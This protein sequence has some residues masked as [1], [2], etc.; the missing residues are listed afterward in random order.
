MAKYTVRYEVDD[1]TRIVTSPSR[2]REGWLQWDVQ[3]RPPM[4]ENGTR[5][6]WHSL[7]N[8]DAASMIKLFHQLRPASG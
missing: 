3:R 2:Q 1:C 6:G 5:G 7:K 8:V 4:R